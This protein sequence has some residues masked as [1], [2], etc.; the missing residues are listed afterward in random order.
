MTGTYRV[1]G[2][3]LKVKKPPMG[4]RGVIVEMATVSRCYSYR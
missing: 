2:V 1:S 3:T 4:Y